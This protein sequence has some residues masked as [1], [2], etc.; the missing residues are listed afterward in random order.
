[1]SYVDTFLYRIRIHIFTIQ[2]VYVSIMSKTC[3][4]YI[5]MCPLKLYIVTCVLYNIKIS[6]YNQ[7]WIF[8]SIRS[9]PCNWTVDDP[10]F[11]LLHLFFLHL[12]FC[13]KL[14]SPSGIIFTNDEHVFLR[15][16]LTNLRVH[17]FDIYAIP[18]MCTPY[19]QSRLN[20]V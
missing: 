7:F 4:R 5:I 16:L 15:I 10:I 6:F 11:A 8:L 9:T 12:L 3:K 19:Y 20:L 18:T 1:M 17:Y 14:F 2:L 13:V